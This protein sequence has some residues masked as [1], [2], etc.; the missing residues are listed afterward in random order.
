MSTQLVTVFGGTGFLGRWI[1]RHLHAAGFAVR[2]ASRHPD[3]GFPMVSSATSRMVSVYGDINHDVSVAAAVHGAFAAVNAVSLYVERERDTFRSV[4]VR[5]AERLAMLARQAGVESFVHVSGIG[6]D[7]RST[8]PYIRSRGQGE[9]AVLEAF[10]SSHILRPAVMFGAGDAFLMPLLAM[11]RR[12]PVFPMF[13]N[14]ETRLQPAYVEDVGEASTRVLQSPSSHRVYEL[15]GPRIYTYR[16]LLRELA[17]RAGS[18]PWLMPMPF[19]LWHA[20]AYLGEF[21]PS[22]PIT[23]NQVE[24][25][26][27][28]NIAAPD[29]P[30][31]TALQIQPQA[32]EDVLPMMLES[33]EN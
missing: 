27:A 2:I 6:A 32:I 23:R 29:V 13:G 22:P 8:S 5:A 1:V 33:T 15:A 14:G 18:R 4:H 20:I 19:Q 11:L 31:F 30:G 10:P 3:R 12:M 16:A 7:T 26:E 25:M 17:A 21:L 9:Q 24:L 28:D